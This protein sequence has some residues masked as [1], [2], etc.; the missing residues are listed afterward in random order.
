MAEIGKQILKVSLQH[1]YSLGCT[2]PPWKPEFSLA[3]L[4]S[5]EGGIGTQVLHTLSAENV[6]TWTT[7]WH[8]LPW[9]MSRKPSKHHPCHSRSKKRIGIT[10][11]VKPKHILSLPLFVPLIISQQAGT[12]PGMKLLNLAPGFCSLSPNQFI[13]A[14]I[15]RMLSPHPTKNIYSHIT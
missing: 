15:M 9:C 10:P 1:K 4:L 5:S 13:P 2:G 3:K 11:Y 8:Q 12:A 6:F 7:P 14:H